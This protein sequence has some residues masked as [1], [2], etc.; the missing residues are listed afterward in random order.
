MN[1]LEPGELARV[2]HG[3]ALGLLRELP[4]QSVDAWVTDPP[5]SSGGQHRGDRAS[6]KGN[7]K[8]LGAEGAE[9]LPDFEGDT[10]DQRGYLV[11]SSL[12]LAEAWRTLRP[13]GAVVVACDW[14]QLPVTSDALQVAGFVWRG[15]VPW[16]KPG[17]RPQVGRFT[18]SGEYFVWGSRGSMPSEGECLDGFHVIPSPKDR[19]HPTEKPI[20]LM[21]SLVRIAPVGGIVGDPFAGSGTTLV[22][23]ITEGRRAWGAELSSDYAAIADRRVRAVIAG[24]DRFAP[25]AQ[26][27]LVPARGT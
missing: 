17:S 25:D 3:E 24:R 14:R 27:S 7:R 9:A 18:A 15:I 6:S 13:G 8:Y 4:D 26:L 12:W 20:E 2:V 1:V 19:E 5:Y 23:A 11:W 10:R 16:L 22:A 21:R